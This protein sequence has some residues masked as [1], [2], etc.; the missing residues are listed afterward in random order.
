MSL[1]ETLLQPEY[2]LLSKAKA[3]AKMKKDGVS[4][5]AKELDAIFKNS[6]FQQVRKGIRPGKGLRIAA[7]N[8]AYQLDV[9]K[10]PQYKGSNGGVDSFLLVVAVKSRKAWAYPLKSGTDAELIRAYTKF[11]EDA[12]LDV[13]TVTGDNQFN[14]K[15]F[16][17]FNDKIGT[18]VYTGIANDDH[19]SKGDR[20]GIVDRAV[21]TLRSLIAKYMELHN[22]VRWTRWLD[23]ILDVYNGTP[24][25]GLRGG[26]PDEAWDKRHDAET[27]SRQEALL[28]ENAALDTNV[29]VGDTVRIYLLK[30]TFGK[31]TARFSRELYTVSGREGYKWRVRNADGK[32]LKRK[33]KGVELQVIDGVPVPAPRAPARAAAERQH[34]HEVRLARAGVVPR[35]ALAEAVKR[36]DEPRA[37]RAAKPTAK[38]IESAVMSAAVKRAPTK[39]RAKP[40]PAAA[41][42]GLV[43][44]SVTAPGSVFKTSGS[45]PGKVTRVDP[46]HKDAVI[47]V[48]RDEPKKEYWFRVEQVMGWVQ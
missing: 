29:K 20:L 23:K 31:E 26:T 17:D 48:F 14:S 18:M 42:S 40:V 6:E 9:I 10:L 33:F 22:T 46:A 28:R 11:Q 5:D 2:E 13:T 15:A 41:A 27:D 37:K 34:G 25:G 21:R 45:Y 38:A 44:R 19:I 24:H 4:F 35:A 7:S 32:L 30:P 8:C 16:R 1:R 47:V 12:G 39:P 3:A 43:G 36:K